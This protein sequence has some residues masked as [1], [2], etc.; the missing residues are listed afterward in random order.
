MTFQDN[1]VGAD[2]VRNHEQYEWW[3]F[4]N[5]NSSDSRGCGGLTGPMA[6]IVS[7][8]TPPRKLDLAFFSLIYFQ[9]H[10]VCQIISLDGASESISH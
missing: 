6:I 3:S 10:Y 4:H 7:E 1:S 9:T 2:L 5:I 8:E